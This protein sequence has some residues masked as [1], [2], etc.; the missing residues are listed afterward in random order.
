MISSTVLLATIQ[1]KGPRE[2][3]NSLAATA[4]TI[5]SDNQETTRSP[6]AVEMTIWMAARDTMSL[7]ADPAQTYTLA[8]K[9]KILSS[10]HLVTAAIVCLISI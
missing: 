6:A 5:C 10:S 9:D 4:R 1:F 3:T 8:T 7:L 2:T